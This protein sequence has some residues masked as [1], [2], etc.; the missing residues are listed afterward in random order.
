MVALTIPRV[1]V[2]HVLD[3]KGLL[4]RMFPRHDPA[5]RETCCYARHLPANIAARR[6]TWS[7]IAPSHISKHRI[8]LIGRSIRVV[9]VLILLVR[10]LIVGC[11][12]A[13]VTSV[14][15]HLL[16]RDDSIQAWSF[17]L[18]I[19]LMQFEVW[20]FLG[21]ITPGLGPCHARR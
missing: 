11:I 9:G 8:S 3:L 14:T 2:L 21:P 1:H 13:A 17:A 7:Q 15:L 16:L 18:F 10:N 4:A 12:D 20:T 19:Y 6:E 5:K